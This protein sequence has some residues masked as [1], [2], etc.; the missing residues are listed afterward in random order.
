MDTHLMLPV[1]LNGVCRIGGGGGY[2]G[3]LRFGLSVSNSWREVGARVTWAREKK[4]LP[5]EI[6]GRR[7]RILV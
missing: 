7:S 1:R 5:L 6:A 2:V 4:T 3:A